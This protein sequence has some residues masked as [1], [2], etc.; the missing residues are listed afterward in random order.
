[1]EL[2]DIRDRWNEVLD[3]LLRQD[4]ITW[5]AFFDARLAKFDGKTLT[6]DFSDSRKFNSSHEYFQIRSKQHQLLIST[7][8]ETLHLEIEIVEL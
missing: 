2:I 4:R 6:L 1:M 3:A 5:L 8:K 7:V